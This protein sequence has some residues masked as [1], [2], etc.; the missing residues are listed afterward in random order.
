MLAIP[1][2]TTTASYDATG[3]AA[4]PATDSGAL[5]PYA[6]G[7]LF[8][9]NNPAFVSIRKGRTSGSSGV[10]APEVLVQPTMVPLTTTPGPPGATD[11]IFGV[12]AR[13]GVAGSHAQVFG[14]LFQPGEASFVPSGQFNGT[15]SPSGG[16][17][18]GTGVI[19]GITGSVSAAGAIVSGT[20]F[21][22]AKGAAGQYTIS[23]TTALSAVPVVVDTGSS[24][25]GSSSV[26][27]YNKTTGGFQV[28]AQT[29]TVG[30]A[31]VPF[32]FIAIVPQ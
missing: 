9:A 30:A 28:S 6:S 18:P 14:A 24:N 5:T 7:F 19:N 26:N 4:F 31:D 23:F 29:I 22:V 8:V 12:R 25:N 16:F 1:N 13:D 17:S 3:A 2:T 11:F 20:G 27:F 32:D 10:W 15:V 21:A